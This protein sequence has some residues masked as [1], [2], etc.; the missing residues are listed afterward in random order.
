MGPAGVTGRGY[1]S[2]VTS[3]T[4][5]RV[6]QCR[7]SGQGNAEVE[8]SATGGRG[9]P[10]TGPATLR[11]EGVP[12]SVT[13]RWAEASWQGLSRLTKPGSRAIVAEGRVG[14][15]DRTWPSARASRCGHVDEE[16]GVSSSAVRRLVQRNRRRCQTRVIGRPD[17]AGRRSRPCGWRGHNVQF[18]RRAAENVGERHQRATARVSG[19]PSTT[20]TAQEG[21]SPQLRQTAAMA[22][23]LIS[24]VADR[25]SVAEGGCRLDLWLPVARGRRRQLPKHRTA[26][27]DS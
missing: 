16:G 27:Y 23:L 6:T 2:L 8:P 10:G 14:R 4:G 1:S 11:R 21:G 9:G 13:P 5:S 19:R 20:A 17:A 22:S 3:T 7:L 24:I 15:G 18:P 12:T 25:R 26:R